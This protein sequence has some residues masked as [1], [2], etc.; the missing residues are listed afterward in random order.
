LRIWVPLSPCTHPYSNTKLLTIPL[1]HTTRTIIS[2]NKE[3]ASK[4]SREETN[5]KVHISFGCK[6]FAAF[7][8]CNAPRRSPRA[9]LAAPKALHSPKPHSKSDN[10]PTS[11]TPLCSSKPLHHLREYLP[12]SES[13]IRPQPI[14]SRQILQCTLVI[15]HPTLHISTQPS[16]IPPKPSV[17]PPQKNQK[18]KNNQDQE[19]A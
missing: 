9:D 11:H 5:L 10:Q 14:S 3:M 13:V 16:H 8:T 19:K 2:P 12:K 18:K 1:G 7:K 6:R 4:G 15:I 17:S